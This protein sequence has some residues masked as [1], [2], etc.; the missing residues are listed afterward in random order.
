MFDSDAY[1]RDEALIGDSPVIHRIWDQLQKAA[2]TE[3]PV[4]ITGESGTGKELAARL[5]HS[6]SARRANH[7]LKVSCPAISHQFFESELYSYDQRSL[8]PKAFEAKVRRCEQ[9]DKGTLF[10]DEVGELD[11]SLQP[12]LL[13]ALQDFQVVRLGGADERPI[14]IRLICATNRDLEAEVGNGR[15]RIDLFYRI[16]VVRIQMP[17]LRE[18]IGDVPILMD[19]F[20]KL[21]SESFRT[22]YNPLRS[23]FVK[24]LESYRWPG[25]V[26]ELENMAKRYVV[27]GGEEHVLS[28]IKQPEELRPLLPEAIDLTTPLRVQ[29]R[30]A[31]QH[32]ERKIILGVLE[33]HNWNRR[34]TARS[35]DISYR[36]LLYKIKEVGLPSGQAINPILSKAAF[37]S[38]G[39]DAPPESSTI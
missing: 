37:Q 26:R 35:L 8:P 29:T 33:A 16:N 20:I 10:L 22:K 14:D 4:L 17:P 36:A 31:T 13:Y 18:R 19:H 24:M 2:L 9:A 1:R 28:A 3:V 25:N 11:Q 21:Y 34:K 38:S 6:W 39:N 32:L 12:K 7:F 23:S 15:F 5:L 27:L 30:R